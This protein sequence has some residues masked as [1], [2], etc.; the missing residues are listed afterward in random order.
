ME[1]YVIQIEKFL[2]GHMSLDEEVDFKISLTANED[3]RSLALLL[4]SMLKKQ[5][6]GKDLV[7]SVFICTFADVN[8]NRSSSGEP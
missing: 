4:A 2:R 8:E 7:H 1:D 6:L 5:K 3:F